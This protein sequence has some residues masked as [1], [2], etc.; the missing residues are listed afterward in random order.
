MV[1]A[2][3]KKR[4]EKK[5][6]ERIWLMTKCGFWPWNFSQDSVNTKFTRLDNLICDIKSHSNSCT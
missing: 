4:G 6:G 5:K 2:K 1:N 3:P